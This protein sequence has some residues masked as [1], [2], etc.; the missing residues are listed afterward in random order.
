MKKVKVPVFL[1]RLVQ[2]FS[3]C[4]ASRALPPP[5]PPP[6]AAKGDMAASSQ[7][8]ASTGFDRPE[9]YKSPLAGSVS[10]YQRHLFVC[11]KDA[12]SWPSQVESAELGG[13]PHALFAAFKAR[14]NDMPNKIRLTV[15]E[16]SDSTEGD[17][18]VFP[19]L[20]RYRGLRASDAESFVEEVV[21][22]EQIWSHGVEEPLSGSHVFICA[23]GAR[24]ARCGS[25]GPV[26]VDKFRDEIEARGL[27]GR[28][29]VKAC[30]HIGGHKFA[31]NVIIYAA[32]GG[33][34]PVSGHWYGYVTPN[35][36]SVLLEQHIERGQIVDKLW[37]GQMGLTEDQ[38]RQSQVSRQ[39]ADETVYACPC[40][41]IGGVCGA[42]Q[43]KRAVNARSV[44][45]AAKA[46]GGGDAQDNAEDGQAT[47]MAPTED[48][49]LQKKKTTTKNKARGNDSGWKTKITQDKLAAAVL[50]LVAAIATG[51][52]FYAS[53]PAF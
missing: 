49:P 50:V 47:K 40:G 43:Q 29:T 42:K 26:L 32:S 21:V 36:V 31:G 51:M 48:E 8:P 41:V 1:H 18:F 53:I 33:G 5:P 45:V 13:L 24:D 16:A 46:K 10:F 9:M 30:S 7:L 22:N 20:V 15:C 25:C 14:K 12:L 2:P 39:T 37:R 35:D 27:S 38:Q 28:V 17:I 6:A 23:H 34:G 19:D 4:S 3:A 52:C 11:Y 44:T